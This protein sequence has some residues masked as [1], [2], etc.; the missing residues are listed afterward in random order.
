MESENWE[1]RTVEDEE[2]NEARP[3]RRVGVVLP[4]RA[5]E[6]VKTTRSSG[7]LA[8]TELGV[9]GNA[10]KSSLV[11]LLLLSVPVVER[12]DDRE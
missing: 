9:Q 3:A 11:L 12:E 7:Q 6:A 10:P 5:K 8:M 2:G 1:E 4:N